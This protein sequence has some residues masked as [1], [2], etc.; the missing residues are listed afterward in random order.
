MTI[1]KTKASYLKNGQSRIDKLSMQVG[2]EFLSL[3]LLNIY[4]GWDISTNS[5]LSYLTYLLTY[6]LVDMGV[7]GLGFVIS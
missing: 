5:N 7:F 6:K 1:E 2:T 4:R 3:T